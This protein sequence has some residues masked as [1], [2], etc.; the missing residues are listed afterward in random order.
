[1]HKLNAFHNAEYCFLG[2]NSFFFLKIKVFDRS[3]NPKALLVVTLFSN[4]IHMPLK[5]KIG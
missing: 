1:M 5:H 2:W 4:L 3:D